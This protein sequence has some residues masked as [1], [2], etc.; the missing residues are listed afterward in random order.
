MAK[1]AFLGH[2]DWDYFP[3]K[4][5]IKEIIIDLIENKEVTEFY[6][7]CR[8]NFDR[9]CID[10]VCE[11]KKYYPHIRL[12]QVLSYHP[13]KS[14]VLTPRFDD[15]VYLLEKEVPQKFAI[16]HTNRRLVE[17]VD[18]IISGVRKSGSRVR[19]AYSHAKHLKKEIKELKYEN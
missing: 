17:L 13:D 16:Y 3:Y 7:G 10:V 4:S 2:R 6:N 1:C 14:F 8:G 5:Q 19:N 15:S 9:I 12:I 18:Y 11:L